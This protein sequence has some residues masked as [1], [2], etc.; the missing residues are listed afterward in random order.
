MKLY[1]DHIVGEPDYLDG[2][3]TKSIYITEYQANNLARIVSNHMNHVLYTI[4]YSG[5]K[6]PVNVALC[7]MNNT[8]RVHVDGE[9]VGIILHEL[10]HCTSAIHGK[11][12]IKNY[13]KFIDLYEKKWRFMI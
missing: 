3:Y 2:H 13:L 12:W 4:K 7:F 1:T 8:I 10:A 9:S 5:K 11:R 6:Q